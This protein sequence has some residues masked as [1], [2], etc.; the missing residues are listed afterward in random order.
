MTDTQ[1]YIDLFKDKPI[2]HNKID[3]VMIQKI[4]EALLMKYVLVVGD[5]EFRI[6]EVEFY[7]RNTTHND[8]YTHRDSHQKTYGRW[9]FHRYPNCSYKGG[10]Y[11][12]LDLTLGNETTYFGV[13]IRSIYDD[14]TDEM[15][16]GPCK[17]VN[18]I[19]ELSGGASDVNE[20]MNGRVPFHSA[21]LNG[22]LAFLATQERVPPLSSRS[23]KNFYLKRKTSLSNETIYKGPRIGLSDKYPEWK[24]IH[25]RYLIKK[26][27][28]KKGKTSLIEI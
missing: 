22:R 2:N 18:K 14:S 13:L 11:K 20:Y 16:E 23:T 25:Y 27:Y 24:D 9:Y 1:R 17:T 8:T 5:K 4:A 19:L 6:C 3:H 7:V 26:K 21:P 12:G 10:T 28:I 15:I